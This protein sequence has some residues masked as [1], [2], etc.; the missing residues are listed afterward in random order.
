MKPWGNKKRVVFLAITP[1]AII[2][3]ALTSYFLVVRYGDVEAALRN[4]GESMV[5]QL[6]PAAEYGTFS[7]NRRELL[8][9]AQSAARWAGVRSGCWAWCPRGGCTA[10]RR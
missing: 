10:A 4:R 1:V 2:A 5:R 6:A 7:G 9:L 3:I 8:R